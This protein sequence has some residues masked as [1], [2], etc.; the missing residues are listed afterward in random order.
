MR[1]PVMTAA[2]VALTLAAGTAS[3]TAETAPGWRVTYVSP[4]T[5]YDGFGLYDVTAT[6][7]QDA[8]AVGSTQKGA[9]GAGAMMR[10]NGTGWTAVTVPG[11][12]GSFNSVSGSSAKNVWVL[13]ATA[14]GRNTAWRWNGTS[15]TSVSIGSYDPADVTVL[16]P[17]NAWA[18]GYDGAGDGGGSDGKA[19][20]W[21]GTAWQTVA[22]PMTARKIDSVSANDI[23]A[24]GENAGQPA[25][26]HWDGT[27]WTTSELPQ[28]PIPE[29]Q[30]GFSYFNDIVALSAGNVWAVG[31]LYWGSGEGLRAEEH[32]R[33]VLMHWNGQKWSLQLG[34]EGDFPLSAS[35]DG[36]G[37][38]WYSTINKT[39]V[40]VAKGGTTT[41]VPVSTA[42]GRQTP[43]IRQ[44]AGVP[45]GTTVLAVGEVAP[46]PGDDESW[47][48]LIE[49]YH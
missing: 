5:G 26:T 45:G 32:N 8:W 9:G 2:L 19:L 34:A 44:L 16:G 21:N 40:H 31:R 10:W 25:A 13:G 7:P 33:P 4:D 15:W 3:A 18:V 27:A 48:A 6:G 42:P 28:V 38:I 41:T 35:P 1:K 23:W 49:Q 17:K 11:S 29:G 46:A 43:E 14:N 47:D 39:L 37:G 22:M 24:V 36:K 12:T 20:H 30:S